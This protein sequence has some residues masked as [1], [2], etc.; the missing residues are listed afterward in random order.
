MLSN[1]IYSK[2]IDGKGDIDFVLI[3]NAGGGHKMFSYQIDMLLNH[4]NILLLDLPGHGSSQVSKNNSIDD[5]SALIF[6]IC[7]QYSLK[8]ICLIGLN[9]GAN[10]AINTANANK[11]MFSKLILIDPP[12]FMQKEFLHEIDLFINKLTSNSYEEFVNMM[13]TNLLAHSTTKKR[14][15]AF[16][17]FMKVDKTSLQEIFQSL[18][19]WDKNSENILSSVNIPT[20]C[21]LTD[22]HHCTYDRIKKIAPKF[23]LGK[24]IGSKCW[25][26]LEVPEQVNA[27]IERFITFHN[28]DYPN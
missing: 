14:Q 15:L 25:A 28:E 4:G 3:H 22:E 16:D 1:K 9:N 12:I 24:V 19:D 11:T 17:L 5:S 10:I 21:I 26:T 2:K 13:I 23:I 7:R 20:L 18:I 6:N 27:M 8:H